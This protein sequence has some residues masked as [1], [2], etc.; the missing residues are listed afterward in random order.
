MESEDKCERLAEEI[1][2]ILGSGIILSSDV[3]HYIDSTFSNPAVSELQSILQ[4]DSN[5]EKDSLMELLFFPDESMQLQLEDMLEKLQISG[6][7]EKK[8]LDSLGRES[9]QVTMQFPEERGFLTLLLPQEVIP[10]F[11]ARLRISKHLDRK[12]CESIDNH[13]GEDTRIRYKV[14]IRNSRFLPGKNKI[15]FLRDLFEKL[16]PQSHDF[17]VCLDFALSLLDELK[18]DKNI[19]EALT[20]KKRFHLRSIQKARQM[21]I[22][23]QKKNM[24]TLLLEGKRMILIDQADARKKMLII[25]RICRAVFGK[26]EYFEPL[27]SGGEHLEIRSDQDIQDIIGK[28]S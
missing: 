20:T 9:L 6:Q 5:C 16:K 3:M 22:Q 4:D 21:E 23:L 12:L 8:V 26:T 14:K 17:N 1:K 13:A 15:R 11:V 2:K 27:D 19:Y 28:L 24:E 10:G 25:D 18:E 7:D